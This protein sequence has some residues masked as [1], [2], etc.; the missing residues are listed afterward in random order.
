LYPG[1]DP[2]FEKNGVGTDFSLMEHKEYDLKG[3]KVSLQQIFRV[4]KKSLWPNREK[5]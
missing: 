3:L 1:P 5:K 2:N 4:K